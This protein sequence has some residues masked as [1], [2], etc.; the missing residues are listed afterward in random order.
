MSRSRPIVFVPLIMIR[1]FG[2]TA[3]GNIKPLLKVI[4]KIFAHTD[5][6]VR[7][8]G[9]SLV[10]TLYTFLG[11]ALIPSLSDLKPVQMPNCRKASTRLMG[12]AKELELANL[13]DIRGKLSGSV[14]KLRPMVGMQMMQGRKRPLRQ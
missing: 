8:E 4:S 1:S 12:T 5:K 3:M 7:A 9:T 11:A 2:V 10:I 14:R 13:Q 6:N